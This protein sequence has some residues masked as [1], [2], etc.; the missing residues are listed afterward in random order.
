MTALPV[1][2]EGVRSRVVS[3]ADPARGR[4]QLRR[5]DG[6][7]QL[8]AIVAGEVP[9][10]PA[11][12]LLGMEIT[13]VE[14]GRVVFSLVADEI[15]ENPMG[16]MHGGIIATLV[17]SAM[18]CA[19]ASILPVGTTYTTLELKTNY[20]RPIVQTTGRLRAEG[21]VV[22]I[23]GRVATTD[24]QVVDDDGT[25]YA[26]ATSTCLVTRPAKATVR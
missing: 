20:I 6:F 9:P 13:E 18:G 12:A 3:W 19:V 7:A 23:G 2:E 1:F 16:T 25:L 21:R 11:A 5:R 14:R 24:A 26:H 17:D 10:P 4:F 8:N 15:H 22:H